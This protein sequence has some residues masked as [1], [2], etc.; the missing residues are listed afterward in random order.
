M[1]EKKSKPEWNEDNFSV[2]YSRNDFE[3]SLPHLADE[4]LIKE[5]HKTIPIEAIV[6]TSDSDELRNP[7]VIAFIRRCSTDQEAEE[8]IDYMEGRGEIS[9]TEAEDLRTQLNTHGVR[10]FG[11]YKESG[12]YE[13]TYRRSS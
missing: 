9:L 7:D 3:T 6:H 1:A 13:R 2:E 12:Y 5:E 4:L 8:I 11:P 10:H